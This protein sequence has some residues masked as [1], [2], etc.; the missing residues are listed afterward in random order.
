MGCRMIPGIVIGLQGR[1]APF[2]IYS[3][4]PSEPII[5]PPE[6]RHLESAESG[7]GQ[8]LFLSNDQI[9]DKRHAPLRQFNRVDLFLRRLGI[10]LTTMQHI[11]PDST[12]CVRLAASKGAFKKRN[13]GPQQA[14][15]R[16]N[17]GSMIPHQPLV[18]PQKPAKPATSAYPG[19]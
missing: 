14:Q 7:R 3:R 19:R 13:A 6:S 15:Q 4:L 11:K 8:L 10:N 1:A 2:D 17:S 16:T 5:F 18:V 12:V 9:P